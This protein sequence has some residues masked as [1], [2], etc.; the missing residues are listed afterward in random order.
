MAHRG[1]LG[2]TKDAPFTFHTAELFQELGTRLTIIT[3]DAPFSSHDLGNYKGLGSS[4]PETREEDQIYIS[5]YITTSQAPQLE[6]DV[7][8]MCR[9]GALVQERLP[10]AQGACISSALCAKVEILLTPERG[11]WWAAQSGQGL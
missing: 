5:D 3:K 11:T 6:E 1:L 2:I 7:F 8:G 4:V 10:S 9:A